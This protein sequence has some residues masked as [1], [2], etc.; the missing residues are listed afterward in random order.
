[1]PV[2]GTNVIGTHG[3]P[4]G[5]LQ[6]LFVGSRKRGRGQVLPARPLPGTGSGTAQARSDSQSVCGSRVT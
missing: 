3:S 2:G 1:M 4:K 5:N 6:A